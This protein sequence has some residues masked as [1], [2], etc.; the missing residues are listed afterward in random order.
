MLHQQAPTSL[1][2][3]V[4]R[5]FAAP[6]AFDGQAL[7]LSLLT[8]DQRIVSG[9]LSHAV[10]QPVVLSSWQPWGPWKTVGDVV[11]VPGQEGSDVQQMMLTAFEVE[12]FQARKP[13]D[14]FVTRSNAAMPTALHSMGAQVYACPC[15]CRLYQFHTSRLASRLD[16]HLCAVLLRVAGGPAKHYRHLTPNGAALLNGLNPELPIYQVWF[17][18][19]CA[20]TTRTTRWIWVT[21]TDSKSTTH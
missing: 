13:L 3:S 20:A 14:C 6:L 18:C 4:W 21:C 12:E 2:L 7:T 5:D 8:C 17:L 19:R 15:G 1:F 11:H 10:Q 9:L 16:D